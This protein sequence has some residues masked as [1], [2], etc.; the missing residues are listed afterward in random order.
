MVL[1]FPPLPGLLLFFKVGAGG[2]ALDII[3]YFKKGVVVV[4]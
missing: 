4:K 2:G 1:L 3:F